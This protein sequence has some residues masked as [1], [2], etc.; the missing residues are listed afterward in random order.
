[1]SV[2]LAKANKDRDIQLYMADR[3]RTKR[4][5]LSN[6]S[7]RYITATNFKNPNLTHLMY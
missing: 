5:T 6:L 1:M 7:D 3:E 4:K 2:D